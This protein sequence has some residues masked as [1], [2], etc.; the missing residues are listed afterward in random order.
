MAI[1]VTYSLGSFTNELEASENNLNA[2]KVKLKYQPFTKYFYQFT[3]V[4]SISTKCLAG[5]VDTCSK[6]LDFNYL[7][8]GSRQNLQI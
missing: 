7:F 2:D 8:L 5:S 4:T 1:R 3:I 6:G